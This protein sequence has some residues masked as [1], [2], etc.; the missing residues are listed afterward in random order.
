MNDLQKLF[1]Q[2]ADL[3]QAERSHYYEEHE[4]GRDLRQEVE[5]LLR[6]DN[7]SAN[8]LTGVMEQFLNS[9]PDRFCGAIRTGAP[10]WQGRH[11]FAKPPSSGCRGPLGATW[12]LSTWAFKSAL[13]TLYLHQ[14]HSNTPLD[15][16]F[17]LHLLEF[18]LTLR[19]IEAARL[20]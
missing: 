16:D 4:V 19:T 17:A 5:S 7:G 13:R 11:R 1:L 20:G 14:G 10:S 6:F 2:V 3:D 9:A 15:T 12:T 18:R 8:L